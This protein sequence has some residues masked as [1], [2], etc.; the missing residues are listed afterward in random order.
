MTLLGSRRSNQICVTST[1][2]GVPMKR[3][4]WKRDAIAVLLTA[5]SVLGGHAAVDTY[6]GSSS[7][8]SR[9]AKIETKIE[10]IGDEV[11]RIRDRLEQRR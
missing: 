2:I 7:V 6:N 10:S 4:R 11:L 5:A 1:A 9:L 8:E 3:E